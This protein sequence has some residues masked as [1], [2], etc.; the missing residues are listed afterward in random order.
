MLGAPRATGADETPFERC[1]IL[2][3]RPNAAEIARLQL[4]FAAAFPQIGKPQIASSWAGLIDVLPDTVPIIDLAPIPGLSIATG[5]SGHGFGIAPG[6]AH[7]VAGLAL[8]RTPR[9][10]LSRFR[11]SRFIDGSRLDLGT[12]I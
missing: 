9:H 3:P 7:L 5:M 8:G 10:E 6:T 1:H 4:R 2:S 11:F 12:V